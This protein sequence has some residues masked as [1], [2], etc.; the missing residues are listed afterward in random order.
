MCVCLCVCVCTCLEQIW[1]IS[2]FLLLAYTLFFVYLCLL[3]LTTLSYLFFL[4]HNPDINERMIKMNLRHN[5]AHDQQVENRWREINEAWRATPALWSN[6]FFLSYVNY[7]LLNDCFRSGIEWRLKN[8][9]NMD[10]FFKW[11]ILSAFREY[12]YAFRIGEVMLISTH[13]A[14]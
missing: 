13:H 14:N 11:R 12:K 7:T 3:I 8:M 5:I 6:M 2:L 9:T 4:R 10:W 1:I